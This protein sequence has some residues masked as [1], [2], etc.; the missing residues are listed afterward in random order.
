ML[1]VTVV[2]VLVVVVVA[3]YLLTCLSA[4][5]KRKLFRETSSMFEVD[6]VKNEV[7]LRDFKNCPA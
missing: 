7:L 4:S 1:V 2:V 5:L 6:N 3:F